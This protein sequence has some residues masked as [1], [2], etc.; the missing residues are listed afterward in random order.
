MFLR[1]GR[2]EYTL[3]R[4]RYH[5]FDRILCRK[6][7]VDRV[8]LSWNTCGP[9]DSTETNTRGHSLGFNGG[10]PQTFNLNQ[11]I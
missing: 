2:A 1:I 9:P 7:I 8:G 3:S 11:H 5:S 6:L 10:S 4:A